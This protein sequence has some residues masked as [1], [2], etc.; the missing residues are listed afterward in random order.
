[1]NAAQQSSGR[2]QLGSAGNGLFVASAAVG[3]LGL[4]VALVLG[5][6]SEHGW[7]R[8]FRSYLFAFCAVTAICLGG[9]F[10]TMLQHATRA[11]WSV[12]LRRIAELVAA[13]LQWIWILFIPVLLSVWF[14]H[15]YHWMHPVGDEL[16]EHKAPFFFGPGVLERNEAGVASMNYE[17]P[18]FWILRAVFVL[19]A[20]AALSR[21]FFRTSVA[22]D[23]TGD[24]N[25]THRMQW[26]AP[27]GL[28]LYALTQSIA[29]IDWIES[30]EAH[31]FSTMFAV[32]FFAASC[33]GFFALMPLI[34][35]GLQRSGRLTEEITKEHYQDAGKL[36]F[37]FGIVFWAYIAY[38][39]YML[40]WYGNIPEETA[41]YLPRILGGWRGFSVF[42]LIGHF[43]LPF[44]LLVTKHTK[45]AM[46]VL[47][48]ICVGMLI[49][50]LVDIYWLVMPVIP[51]GTLDNYTHL[52][53]LQNAVLA[54]EVDVNFH[55][56]F[57]DVACLL[58]VFGLVAAATLRRMTTCSLIPQA[59]PRLH[60]SL[61]FENF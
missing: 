38:S 30:L 25:L 18:W 24:V 2:L 5:A 59:D 11:G 32:Y 20:W 23:A 40:I 43:V 28:L 53:A 44:L 8:F 61:A 46:T 55:P 3:V 47:A 60:E 52:Q 41:W 15:Q 6:V 54:G 49:M 21:F 42:L 1:M 27:V 14:G 9:L 51:F 16:L 33:C 13:N 17:V 57:M 48:V 10:F 12:V 29:A 26:W 45:R 37:A 36:L 4:A 39:Q 22:Q 34:M 7:D 58:G 56:S 31:W 19:A 50:H 35:L